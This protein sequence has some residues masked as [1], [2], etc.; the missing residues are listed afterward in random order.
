[1]NNRFEHSLSHREQNARLLADGI[2]QPF[3][4]IE[5]YDDIALICET[6]DR[7]NSVDVDMTFGY[8]TVTGIERRAA[9]PDDGEAIV[10]I[11]HIERY[12]TDHLERFATKQDIS[13]GIMA[14]SIVHIF[15]NHFDEL[16]DE[17]YDEITNMI[18][19][20]HYDDPEV[21]VQAVLDS[22][23]AL[24]ERL[25]AVINTRLTGIQTLHDLQHDS[26]VTAY[27]RVASTRDGGTE[28]DALV[29]LMR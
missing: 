14:A 1:M 15:S 22:G 21:V 13:A 6:G 25:V 12:I 8:R 29:R 16:P 28:L 17:L 2:G 7:I 19:R 5:R 10:G 4:V 23:P 27:L 9:V 3:V 18:Q 11:S 24:R 20:G 26:L